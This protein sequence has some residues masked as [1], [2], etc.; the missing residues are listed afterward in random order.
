[1]SGQHSQSPFSKQ[2]D[3]DRVSK[4][5]T[6]PTI[7]DRGLDALGGENNNSYINDMTI[8][9]WQQTEDLIAPSIIIIHSFITHFGCNDV[10]CTNIFPFGTFLIC[11][12]S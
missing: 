11:L 7:D 6:M 9:H 12:S 3:D 4:N 2:E 8:K 5:E 1:M 10:R